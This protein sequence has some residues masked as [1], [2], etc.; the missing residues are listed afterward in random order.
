MDNDEIIRILEGYANDWKSTNIKNDKNPLRSLKQNVKFYINDE[1][2]KTDLKFHDIDDDVMIFEHGKYH[3]KQ[4]EPLEIILD[5]IKNKT[6]IDIIINRNLYKIYLKGVIFKEITNLLSKSS[7]DKLIVK[8]IYDN[9]QYENC[10]LTKE[11]KRAIQ[12]D[13]ILKKVK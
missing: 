4:I 8:F 10:L 1:L 2:L 5:F 12:I 3:T 11:E 13:R 7:M 6:K 9:I